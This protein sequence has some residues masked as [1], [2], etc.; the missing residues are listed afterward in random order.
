MMNKIR[1]SSGIQIEV[2]DAGE[3]ITINTD[4]QNFIQ[5][6]Y[7]LVE[8]LEEIKQKV[9]NENF[10]G[11]S[12]HDRLEF[13]IEQIRDLMENMDDLFGEDACRKIFGDIVP[14]PFLIAEFFEQMIPVIKQY[15]ST[16][17]DMISKKYSRGRISK[18]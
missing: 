4:D 17:R 3:T 10:S 14:S 18:G 16:R 7:G 9:K 1:V 12:E 11:K 13:A 8:K 5:K 2:N 6:F 15:T